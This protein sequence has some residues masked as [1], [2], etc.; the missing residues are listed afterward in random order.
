LT[1]PTAESITIVIC[2]KLEDPEAEKGRAG[3]VFDKAKEQMPAS[4]WGSIPRVEKLLKQ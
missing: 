2:E 4:T 1:R 3:Q